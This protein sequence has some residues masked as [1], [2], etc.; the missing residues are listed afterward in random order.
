[1]LPNWPGSGKLLAICRPFLSDP[2]AVQGKLCRRI[3]RHIKELFVFVA[4]PD[5]PADNNPAERS[6]RHLVISRKVSGGTRSEQWYRAQ[7]D[8]G[9][10]LRH[11]ARPRSKSSRRLP[12]AARFPSTLNCYELLTTL[13]RPERRGY[14]RLHR[15]VQAKPGQS[16]NPGGPT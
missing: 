14:N 10:H 3:E 8:A 15:P 5:V 12:S 13:P 9:I 6:L 1:M 7:D 2:S 16:D 11:L 4:E